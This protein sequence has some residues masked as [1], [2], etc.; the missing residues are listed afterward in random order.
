[1]ANGVDPDEMPQFC[2]VSS[3]S[4]LFAVLLNTMVYMV[5]YGMAFLTVGFTAF[6]LSIYQA[7]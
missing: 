6:S 7:V 1:M 4:T 3:G 5:I 2:R